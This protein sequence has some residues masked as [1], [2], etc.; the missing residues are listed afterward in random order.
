VDGLY[1]Y[2]TTP[3]KRDTIA[4]RLVDGRPV[5]EW[6]RREPATGAA[7]FYGGPITCLLIEGRDAWMAGPAE[8]ATDGSTDRA[9]FIHVHD[10]G[11]DGAG[12]TAFMWLST[13][14]QT[15]T[16]ME[17][18]CERQVVLAPLYPLSSGDITVSVGTPG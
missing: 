13:S 18:W 17:Q 1:V 4:V 3:P 7:D 14:G 9:A 10:G 8:T 5:G 16:T 6:S 12:D 2:G 15:I 11:Q